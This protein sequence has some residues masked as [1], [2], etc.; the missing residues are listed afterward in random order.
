MWR[1]CKMEKVSAYQFGLCLVS[2]YSPIECPSIHI[3]PLRSI[4]E[5]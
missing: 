1:V 3:A 4:P 5:V 2:K